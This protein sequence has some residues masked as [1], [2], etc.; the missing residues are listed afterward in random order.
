MTLKDTA[1]DLLPREV[2]EQRKR[3]FPTPWRT[4]LASGRIEEV[5]QLLL[6]PRSQERRFFRLEALRRLF[7]EH[8]N[9]QFDHSNRIWRLLNLELWHRVFVD[10]DPAYRRPADEAQVTLAQMN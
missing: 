9:H 3:G 5:E 4:W 1:R 10:A 7:W 6:E 2:I 8:R